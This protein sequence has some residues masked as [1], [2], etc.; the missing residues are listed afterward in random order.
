MTE[1]NTIRGDGR[2]IESALS[3]APPGLWPF[4]AAGYPTVEST[5]L[6]LRELGHLPIR[7]IE[8]GFPFSDP[9]ADGPVIQQAFSHALSSGVR[10]G[11]VLDAIA[12][13]RP[14]VRQPLIGMISASIVYRIGVP[15]FVDRAAKAGLDG[16]IVPDI[17]LE[18]APA[19]AASLQQAGLKLAML[20]AP[21]TPMDRCRRIAESAGGFLYYVSIQG[22]TGARDALPADLEKSVCDIRETTGM[23]VMVGFGI[24]RAE[25]VRRVCEFANGAIVGSAIMQRMIS[26]WHETK[27]VDQSRLAAI[28]F[29]RELCDG[30]KKM[31]P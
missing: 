10:V 13:A 24:S 18:E 4:I 2:R 7:G 1:P 6:L 30:T 29:V 8:I 3:E 22:T 25:H 26:T 19:L 20:V 5:A 27:G 9:I 12:E 15:G 14:H 31:R 21:T 11:Q 28:S 16:L 17:S 23:A